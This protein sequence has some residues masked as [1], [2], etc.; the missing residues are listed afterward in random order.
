MRESEGQI[1]ST[2]RLGSNG[3]W[4]AKELVD[5]LASPACVVTQLDV[6]EGLLRRG[7]VPRRT[8][9]LA[10]GHDE[11]IGGHDGAGHLAYNSCGNVRTRPPYRPPNLVQI[12]NHSW[13]EGSGQR[14][15]AR[16]DWPEGAGRRG[17]ARRA[18]PEGTGQRG[19]G[20]GPA[21]TP[22]TG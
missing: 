18:W 21:G 1:S 16:E 15:L 19:V 14:G 2:V 4:S 7:V 11:E 13:P 20:R 6:I 12:C 10:C 22:C 5:A 3:A 8:L 9:F 17:L